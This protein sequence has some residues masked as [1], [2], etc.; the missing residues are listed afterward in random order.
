MK[1][2]S[3]VM[4]MLLEMMMMMMKVLLLHLGRFGGNE[5]VDFPSAEV[6]KPKELPCLR[7]EEHLHLHTYLRKNMNLGR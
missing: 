4:M 5:G 2:I 3:E 6:V 1:S 7:R